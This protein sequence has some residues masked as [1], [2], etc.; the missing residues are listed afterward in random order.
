[1][2]PPSARDYANAARRWHRA[3]R[4]TLTRTTTS[5]ADGEVSDGRESVSQCDE[6]PKILPRTVNARQ[7][8][9]FDEQAIAALCEHEC[10]TLLAVTDYLQEVDRSCA[11]A[12]SCIGHKNALALR[13]DLKVRR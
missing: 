9:H 3:R 2:L 13:K 6:E 4:A 5:S 11:R 7:L 12:P 10:H 1:M 8:R